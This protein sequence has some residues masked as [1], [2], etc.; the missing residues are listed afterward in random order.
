MSALKV[1]A[2]SRSI[3]GDE[4]QQITVLHESL[5][6]L[7]ALLAGDA[8]V[9]DRDRIGITQPRLDLVPQVVERILGLGEDNQL[10]AIPVGVDH[11]RVVEDPVQLCPLRIPPRMQHAERLPLKSLERIDLQPELFD[12]FRRCRAGHDQILET[13]DLVLSV[14]VQ[15]LQ[16]IVIHRYGAETGRPAFRGEPG[17]GKL[18]FEPFT[19]P[20]E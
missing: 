2:F 11:Q 18:A 19:P 7:A 15:I 8:T 20:L 14:L 1:Y 9:D 4:H 12:G 5:D 13:V 10:A 17:F 3:V 6:D 16:D